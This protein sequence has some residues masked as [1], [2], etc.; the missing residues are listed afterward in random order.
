MQNRT[1]GPSSLKRFAL[2]AGNPPTAPNCSYVPETGWIYGALSLLSAC[3]SPVALFVTGMWMW[4]RNPIACGYLQVTPSWPTLCSFPA[5]MSLVMLADRRLPAGET[6]MADSVFV[7]CRDEPCDADRQ[8]DRWTDRQTDTC[9]GQRGLPCRSVRL[10]GGRLH[11][12]QAGRSVCQAA[13]FMLVKLVGLSGGRLHAGQAGRSV[14]QAAAFML[15]KLVL[16]PGLMV[17]CCFAV[18]LTGATARA[19]VLLAALPVSEAAFAL[20]KVRKMSWNRSID[21]EYD[22]W[23]L[24]GSQ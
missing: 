6:V 17:A 15:V 13:A 24:F 16:V 1:F 23:S 18:G 3:T 2:F 21:A 19:A 9:D 14:C 11:A 7:P 22:I 8:T 20:S 12:G 4:G 5:G 10:S